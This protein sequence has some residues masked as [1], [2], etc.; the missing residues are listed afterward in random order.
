MLNC[1]I[2]P[3]E[4]K[5][6]EEITIHGHLINLGGVVLLNVPVKKHT[7]ITQDREKAK[8]LAQ[9]SNEKIETQESSSP[10]DPDVIIL[11]KVDCNTLAAEPSRPSNSEDIKM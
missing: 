4:V 2:T 11:D 8:I 7:V 9:H 5:Y 1:S 6:D 3:E 10:Q